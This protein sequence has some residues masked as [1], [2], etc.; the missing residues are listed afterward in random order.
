M[1]YQMEVFH[2]QL[3]DLL[4]NSGLPIGSAYYIMKDCLHELEVGYQQ[5]ILSEKDAPEDK[6]TENIPI[7]ED[8]SKLENESG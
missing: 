5:A 8:L 6:V 1:N 7:N 2:Q 4:N 3:I